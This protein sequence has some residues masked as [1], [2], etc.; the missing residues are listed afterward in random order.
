M[1]KQILK[2]DQFH[3]GLN[4]DSDPRD[5]VD[6][7]LSAA[8]DVMVDQIGRITM[9]GG[10]STSHVAY[11]PSASGTITSGY[12]LF[13]FSHDRTGGSLKTSH[14][15]THTGGDSD[16]V[17]I[18]SAAAFTAELVGGTVHNLTDGS[19]GRSITIKRNYI[20]TLY[21]DCE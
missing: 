3:G 15:G 18:D 1:P 17:L 5:I 12:G 11:S 16:T 7:E 21:G 9:M 4:T 14:E 2:I 8:T 10:T 20:Q 19:T 6:N 13:Q